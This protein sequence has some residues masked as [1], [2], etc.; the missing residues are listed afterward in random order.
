MSLG[1]PRVTI[2]ISEGLLAEVQTEIARTLQGSATEPE[3][4]T[5]FIVRAIQ[6]RIAHR[7]R[8]RSHRRP[9]KAQRDE[10]LAQLRYTITD[11]CE[12]DA[13]HD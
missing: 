1:S 6:E 2:R 13:S 7:Q 5:A 10:E 9:T 12:R 4:V 11:P 3:D 8:S